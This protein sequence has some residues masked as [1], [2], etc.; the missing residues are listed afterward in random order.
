VHEESA[1]YEKP[2]T[3]QKSHCS[4]FLNFTKLTKLKFYPKCLIDLNIPDELD[5]CKYIVDIIPK[6]LTVNS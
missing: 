1:I 4:I 2:Q 3:N 5:N 6:M